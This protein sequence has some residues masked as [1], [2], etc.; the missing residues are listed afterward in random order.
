MLTPDLWPMHPPIQWVLHVKWQGCDVDNSPPPN[1]E[2]KNE[3]SCTATPPICLPGVYR[4]NFT[5]CP[6]TTFVHWLGDFHC[7]S[8]IIHSELL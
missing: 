1:F 5:P 6:Q 8:L 3:W 4:D 2:V 7:R